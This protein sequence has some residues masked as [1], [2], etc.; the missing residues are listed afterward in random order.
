MGF[1]LKAKAWDKRMYAWYIP[2]SEKRLKLGAL[3][4]S[5]KGYFTIYEN[6]RLK[7]PLFFSA[8]KAVLASLASRSLF[9]NSCSF[10]TS[11]IANS[12]AFSSF[13]LSFAAKFFELY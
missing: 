11:S 10:L 9:F 4:Y 12:L 6:S 1:F 2:V 7:K 5:I 3:I 13:L 8:F